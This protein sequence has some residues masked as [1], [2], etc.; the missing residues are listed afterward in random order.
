MR[1]ANV[2]CLACR[3]NGEI[4]VY[5]GLAPVRSTAYEH[6]GRS[7]ASGY[8]YLL[9]KCCRT[10]LLIDPTGLLGLDKEGAIGIVWPGR[11]G[12]RE[13]GNVF[14]GPEKIC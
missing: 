13:G 7:I 6:L 1:S 14:S 2:D 5:P 3:N 11:S 4:E 12:T 8:L 9:C 10:V